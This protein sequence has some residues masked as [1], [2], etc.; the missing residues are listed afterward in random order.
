MPIPKITR[1]MFSKVRWMS[2]YWYAS[3][4]SSLPIISSCPLAMRKFSFISCL[5]TVASHMFFVTYFPFL[6]FGKSQYVVLSSLNVCVFMLLKAFSASSNLSR[7]KVYV[8]KLKCPSCWGWGRSVN[9]E[10]LIFLV[11]FLQVI[12]KNILSITCLLAAHRWCL[13]LHVCLSLSLSLRECVEEMN[14]TFYKFKTDLFKFHSLLDWLVSLK[15]LCEPL[16]E[17]N[18][19]LPQQDN[20]LAKVHKLFPV[21]VT[22]TNPICAKKVSECIPYFSLLLHPYA[23]QGCYAVGFY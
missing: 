6:P 7:W 17:E 16:G 21:A 9:L 12:L 20:L 5:L 11:A 8:K 3:S 13:L 10:E 1:R 19:F 14:E 22:W 2:V 18:Q 23:W 15:L 4:A